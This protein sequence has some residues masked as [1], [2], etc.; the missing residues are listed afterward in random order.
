MKENM[1]CQAETDKGELLVIK[2]DGFHHRAFD[3]AGNAVGEPF[4]KMGNLLTSLKAGLVANTVL[5]A[6]AEIPQGQRPDR[7]PGAEEKE[8][9]APAAVEKKE[10]PAPSPAPEPKVKNMHRKNR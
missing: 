2:F 9:P 5:I 7:A 8:E 4:I 6:G 10:E 3:T 1:E